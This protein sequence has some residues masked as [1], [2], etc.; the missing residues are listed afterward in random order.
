[1]LG[2]DSILWGRPSDPGD[3]P[4]RSILH[5]VRMLAPF[6]EALP[7]CPYLPSDVAEG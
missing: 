4:R 3:S 2:R 5:C 7:E 1:M 6:Q